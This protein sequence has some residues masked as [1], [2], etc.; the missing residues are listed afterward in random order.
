MAAQPFTR[1]DVKATFATPFA[2][3]RL[4]AAEALNAALRPR[5]LEREKQASGNV[6]SNVGGWQ[7]EDDF[8]DWSGAEGAQVIEAGKALA[9]RLTAARDGRSPKP[10]WRVHAWA[11]INRAGQ[12]NDGHA[13]PGNFWSAC[14]YVDDA[15]AGD[16]PALGGEF[17]IQDPRGLA[18]A[19]YAPGLVFDMPDGGAAGA[20][21]LFRPRAGEMFLFPS[22]LNHSVRPYRGSGTRISI[23]FNMAI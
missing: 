11:N 14:Y 5:I 18:P 13:H 6:I 3:C 9:S 17:E 12:W 4:A 16:D 15:G 2:V 21:M 22:W 20:A 7:S 1:V 23:A 8:L 10:A 19:M